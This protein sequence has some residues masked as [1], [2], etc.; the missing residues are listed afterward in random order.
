MKF[1]KDTKAQQASYSIFTD[2]KTQVDAFGFVVY[3]NPVESKTIHVR[4]VNQVPGSYTLRLL[5][6]TGQ[7]LYNSYIE[8]RDLNYMASVKL[9]HSIAAGRYE[10][11]IL[12]ANGIES[13]QQVIIK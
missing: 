2:K 13:V 5:S 9:A 6:S 12:S 7:L 4:F 3:P 10:L 11:S 8:V 1:T